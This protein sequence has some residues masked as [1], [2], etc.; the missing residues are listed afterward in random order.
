LCGCKYKKLWKAF[1][2][3]GWSKYLP[4]FPDRAI[5][6]SAVSESYD[7]NATIEVKGFAH[8]GCKKLP[9]LYDESST[10]LCFDPA[11]PEDFI[12]DTFANMT[13]NY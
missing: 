3:P 13:T 1:F 10:P 5:H 11:D 4:P 7:F 6:H 2:A 8:C 9:N 12:D